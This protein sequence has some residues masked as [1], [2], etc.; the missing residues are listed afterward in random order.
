MSRSLSRYTSR[1]APAPSASGDHGGRGAGNHRVGD[2]GRTTEFG[3]SAQPVPSVMGAEWDLG[4]VDGGC[5]RSV[6]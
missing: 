6:A 2:V 4:A 5:Y 1:E 3:A